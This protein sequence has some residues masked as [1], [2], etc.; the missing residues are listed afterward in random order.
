MTIDPT[1]PFP[2]SLYGWFARAVSMYPTA[3]A[4]EIGDHVVSY[5]HL[6]AMADHLAA[7]LLRAGGGRRPRRV[8][9]L[10][11]RT[12]AAYAGYLA[13][14]RLG[15]TVVPLNPS[16]PAARNAAITAA[17]GLEL[18]LAQEQ[19]AGVDLPAEVLPVPDAG[20]LALIPD[21]ERET[22]PYGDV[23]PGDLAYILFTSGSTG[24]PKG[25]PIDHGN[26]CTYLSHIVRHFG[27]GPGSRVSQTFDL[28]F[29]LSVLDLFTAWGAGATLVVPGRNDIL[30]P[31]RFVQ[32]R[33][34]THWFSVPSVISFAQRL[35]ALEPG[36]MPTLQRSMFAGE[37]LTVQQ[38]RAW[39]EAAPASRVEN[40]YG[41]TEVTITC[42]EYVLP[43]RVADW[44]RPANGT[45]PIG[46]GYRGMEYVVLDEH[47]RPAAEGELCVRGPQRFPGYLDP[48]DNAGRFLSFDGSVAAP[49]DTGAVLTGEHWYRTGDRVKETDAG[50]VHCGRL[51]HQVKI[52]GYRVE[53]GEIEAVLRDQPGVRDAIVVA[54][55]AGGGEYALE[56]AY[57]GAPQD[58][59]ELFAAL[60]HRLPAYMVPNSLVA[61]EDFP[62]NANGK[63]DRRVL[64][65]ELGR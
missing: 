55:Q 2:S 25:V 6:E 45:V 22:E 59:R 58:N 24:A 4:L 57:T 5:A 33:R 54:K 21:A 61:F 13:A 38:A 46:P 9:L 56:A 47:G 23:E 53:L 35:R 41:P 18:V 34:L 48:A 52:R 30:A 62:L 27:V 31:V 12:V 19:S 43:S 44:P 63:I 3:P 16:F 17:A 14:Q 39:Q 65:E 11:G 20:L 26:I 42:T 29:D 32:R 28:T 15:A 60:R 50:Y 7:R 1:L 10:A 64:T 40:A 51:D 8:G 36:S 49:Y 37:P